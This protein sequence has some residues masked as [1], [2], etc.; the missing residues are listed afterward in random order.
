MN[1]NDKERALSKTNLFKIK[2]ILMQ[3][4]K[5]IQIETDLNCYL[6]LNWIDRLMYWIRA[7]NFDSGMRSTNS[8]KKKT[9][10][11]TAS[12]IKKAK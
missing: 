4:K 11:L 12:P 1:N 6:I 3:S 5:Y 8:K 7:T 2:V 10:S 9:K